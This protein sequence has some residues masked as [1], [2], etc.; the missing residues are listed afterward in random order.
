MRHDRRAGAI[1]ATSATLF[2]MLKIMGALYLIWLGIRLW[3]TDPAPRQMELRA[4]GHSLR[5]VFWNTYAVTALNPK[6]IVFFVAFVPQFVDPSQ[7][8]L[9]QFVI[10]EATFL[11]M[12]ACNIALWSHLG[13][14]LRSRLV[15]PEIIRIMNRIG[16]SFLIGAGALTATLRRTT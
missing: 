14:Y 15:R 7:P 1:L 2:T 6:D 12:V 5:T 8:V 3:K 16:A 11:F 9:P 4:K 13:G 10:L